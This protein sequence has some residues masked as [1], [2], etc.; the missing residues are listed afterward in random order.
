MGERIFSKYQYGIEAAN[1][2]GSI[3][4]STHIL[5]GADQKPIPEDWKPVFPEDNL[6]VRIRS[7]RSLKSELYVEDTISVG[8]MY[9]EALPFFLSCGLKGAVTANTT[10]GVS[11]WDFSPALNTTNAPDSFTLEAGDDT[12]AFVLEYG[13]FKSL[14]ISGE[15]D[16]GGGESAVKLEAPY[17]A[18]QVAKANFTAGLTLGTYTGMSAK[19][20]R[21]YND[22]AWNS[23]G[24]TEVTSTLRAF[25]LELQFGNHPK[26]FGSANLYFDTHGEAFLD[27]ML[28]LTLEGNDAAQTIWDEWD[29]QD[30]RAVRLVVNGPLIGNTNSTHSLTVDI[31]GQWESVKPINAESNNNNLTQ[32]LF[33]GLV[34]TS[35]ANAF[36]CTVVTDTNDAG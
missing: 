10:D 18:R 11:T 21:L 17:F 36:A 19:L 13:M 9:F 23:V 28:T 24:N 3:V 12:Q 16:Q 14:K 15:I 8:R 32:A 33:H 4:N 2:H 26:F 5:V 34:D 20:A 30:Y 7:S 6:G 35:L 31:Y 27:A 25:E 1:A 29:A 22:S